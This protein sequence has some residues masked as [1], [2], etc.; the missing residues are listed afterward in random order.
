MWREM[1]RI[2]NDAAAKGIAQS[3][4][5][6][7]D[8]FFRAIRHSNEVF[9]A[10]KV[11]TMGVSMA[12]K[13]LDENGRLKSF[14]RWLNDVQGI[15]SHHIGSWLRT[16]YDTAVLRAHFAADWQEFV[17][18]KDILPNLRWMPTTSPDAE[19]T[20]RVYWEKKLTLPVDH[21]FWA[22]HHPRDRWNCKCSLEATDDPAT[23]DSVI[24]GIPDPKPHRGL[25]NNPGKDGH[26]INDTHPYFPA[27]CNQCAFCKPNLK[28]K[29]KH[30]FNVRKKDCFNCSYIKKNLPYETKELIKQRRIEYR[31]LL[32]DDKY[33]NVVFDKKTGGLKAFH[34]GHITH[35]G[36]KA[37]R[38]FGGLTSSDLEQ[39]CM[40]ELFKMGHKV[41]FCDESAKRNGNFLAALDMELNNIKMDIRSVTGNGWYSNIFVRKNEQLHRYNARTDITEKA[42]TLCLYFHEPTL[43]NETNM[44]KSINKF[45]HMRNDDGKLLKQYLKRVHC[46]IKGSGE[47]KTYD[48]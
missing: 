15:T 3:G 42:D 26:L 2:L 30:F 45:R 10:F 47:I 36:K 43:F 4:S 40:N 16:E 20:H 41:I 8:E 5:N 21:P 39:E 17:A 28:N 6:H 9:S 46:V 31:Q 35:E 18:N 48:I 37:E 27:S 24:D 25:E 32:H 19:A 29:V 34:V 14:D 22:K 13:L 23:P 33:Y 1:L 38:F 11:H 7:N 44:K 12:D